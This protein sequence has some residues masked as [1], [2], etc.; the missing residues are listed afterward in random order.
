MSARIVRCR[1]LA[2]LVAAMV[3][4]IAHAAAPTPSVP[5]FDSTRV[6]RKPPFLF[7][8]AAERDAARRN[9]RTEWGGRIVAQL[10]ED[11]RKA[12]DVKL[13]PFP[14]EWWAA[15][16]DRPWSET[17]PDIFEHTMREPAAIARPLATLVHDHIVSGDEPAARRAV[18]LLMHLTSF[19]FEPEHYDVGMNYSVWAWQA[20]MAYD[21]LFDRLDADQRRTLDNFFTRLGRAVLA[22]DEYWIRNNIGGGINNH[23]AWHKLMLG[24]LGLFY[25]E[26]PLVHYALRGPRGMIELLERGCTDD[27]LWSE[28]S[29][30]YQFAAIVPMVMFADAL[31]HAGADDDLFSMTLADGRT[32]RQTLDSM[33]G[34]LFPDG[35]IPPIGDA[36]GHRAPLASQPIYET[37]WRVWKDPRY[38]WLLARR[39]ERPVEALW[40]PALPSAAPPPSIASRLYPEHGYVLL[41]SRRDA[42]YWDSDAWCAFLTYDR[43]GVHCNADKLGLMLFG[44]RTLLLPDV[45]GR[46]TVPHAFSASIQRELNRGALSQNTVMIDGHDQQGVAQVLDLIEYR[47]LPAEKRVT[48]ADRRGLLYAGVAQQRTIC[49]TDA[50]VLDVFQVR[51]DKPRSIDWIM[52]A[53]DGQA[54][55][56][57]GPET[58]PVDPPSR[59][60]PWRWLAGFREAP[61]D[62]TWTIAWQSGPVHLRLDMLAEPGTR[63]LECGYPVTDEPD[64]AR[65]PMLLVRRRA[66]STV[67][68]AVY[69]AGRSPC[70]PVTLTQGPWQEGRLR[71]IVRTPTGPGEHLV[72]VLAGVP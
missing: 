70:G 4:P 9:A 31:R 16:K 63:V 34:V 32:L 6:P 51:C 29:L 20:L 52:H 24:L 39:S 23:L 21:A 72:P 67:F 22:N 35:T 53:L 5:A 30:V 33:F 55:R 17:Y 18:E 61:V 26:R 49:V 71:F 42:A 44:Q 62:A 3:A 27:G 28:S 12:R 14:R 15:A 54:T 64:T 10:T 7:V 65:L 59:D 66:A 41:R 69:T 45:E 19:S 56:A 43:S 37:A 46:A 2:L 25:N 13:T 11:A 47:D 40:A 38:A 8:G 50:Y 60:G 48:A 57:A 36:Y 68:A 1:G 58:K